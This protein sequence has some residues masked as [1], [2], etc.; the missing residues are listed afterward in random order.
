M[1]TVDLGENASVFP[2]GEDR[3]VY[4]LTGHLNARMEE[5]R[6]DGLSVRCVR[7]ERDDTG[8]VWIRFPGLTGKEAVRRL[9]RAY[10]IKTC[11]AEAEGE[12]PFRVTAG[13][14][15]E[16]M[17]YVQGAVMDLCGEP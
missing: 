16:D 8:M 12:V 7:S 1:R 11:P 6:E 9:W 15:F 2:S 17:D 13:V 14:T 4:R 10:R 3:L 5:L